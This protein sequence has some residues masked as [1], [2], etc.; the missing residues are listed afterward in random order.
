MS[1][2]PATPD[3]AGT[4]AN[5]SEP[6]APLPSTN[7]LT[8][9]SKVKQT[10]LN[11]PSPASTYGDTIAGD[12]SPAT[13]LDVGSHDHHMAGLIHSLQAGQI[14][15]AIETI[16]GSPMTARNAKYLPQLERRVDRSIFTETQLS[17]SKTGNFDCNASTTSSP[18]TDRVKNIRESPNWRNK[19]GNF[20]RRSGNHGE[21]P[22]VSS[23]NAG[24]SQGYNT[25]FSPR[26]DRTGVPLSNDNAQ[27]MLPPRA[28]VF[29][30]NLV[31]TQSDDQLEHHVHV[32]FLQ[33][34]TCYVKIRRDARGMPF[35]FVQYEDEND[36]QRAISVGRG[37]LINGRPCRTEVAKV[38]RSLY[39]SKV[40]GGPISETEARNVLSRHGPIESI[41]LCSQTDKEMFRLPDGIWIKFV[42]FQDCRDAQAIFRDHSVYRLEQPP[43]P[44]EVRPRQG[45]RKHPSMSPMQRSSPGRMLPSPQYASRRANAD[46]C[47]IFVGNLPPDATD[48]QLRDMFSMFGPINHVEIVRKPSVHA[49]INVFAFIEYLSPDMAVAAVQASPR[50]YGV[51]RLRVERKEISGTFAPRD[52]V[53]ASGGSP[54]SPY[55][56]D[57]HEQMANLLQRVYNFGM[58]QGAQTQAMP[59]PVYAPY[60]YYQPYDLSQYGQ[61]ATSAAPIDKNTA[62]GL[63][64]DDNGFSA[65]AMG[66]FQYPPAPTSYLQYPQ[67]PAPRPYQWPPAS[68]SADNDNASPSK[69]AF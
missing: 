31:Q 60:P 27:A 18:S 6:K 15:P 14:D 44:E 50:M 52:R 3:K 45:G 25:S 29:V 51:D 19:D 66:H 67:Q 64:T 57:S 30:A 9:T 58:T 46:L 56:A 36:A 13:P 32:A 55:F 65:Q 8:S 34:G 69:G 54:G 35:A 62:T 43:L 53:F 22:F 47:S 17:P 24:Q 38:N 10:S 42:Y 33:Y 40:S 26:R 16:S 61:F 37:M 39:L 7:K 1:H 5:G 11:E 28:C 21:D 2:S 41:W 59:P 23:A 4:H 48:A 49:G 63:Q 20:V 12:S 68:A